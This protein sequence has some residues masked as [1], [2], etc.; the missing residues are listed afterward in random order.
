MTYLDHDH[1]KRENVRFHTT[2]PPKQDLRRG[3]P[4]GLTTLMRDGPYGIQVL[5]YG[6]EA[7]IRDACMTRVVHKDVR[8]VEYQHGGTMGFRTAT[9]SLEVPVNHIAGVEVA[10]ALSDVEQLVTEVSAR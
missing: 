2:F 6:G 10:Q 4:R 8:L 7:K 9:Y 3:P 5:S 1:G